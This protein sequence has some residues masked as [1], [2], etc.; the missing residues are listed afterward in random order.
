[1]SEI[2]K[3]FSKGKRSYKF[4]RQ[5][6]SKLYQYVTPTGFYEC[7]DRFDL[8]LQAEMVRPPRSYIKPE[9]V[10]YM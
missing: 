2:P 6:N 5:V 8:G 10:V 3:E 7:F 4:V 1:M 9:K